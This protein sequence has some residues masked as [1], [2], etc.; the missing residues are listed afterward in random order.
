MALAEAQ[1]PAGVTAAVQAFVKSRGSTE[2]PK[3]KHAL[4]DLNGDSHKEA[5]VFLSDSN[6]CGSGGCTMLV[7]QGQAKGFKLVSSSTV[8]DTPVRVSSEKS[9]GWKHLLVYS[10]GKG[11]VL[12][13]FDGKQY[14]ANPS[15]QPKATPAQLKSAQILLK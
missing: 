4:T 9:H 3:F 5:V 6:W 8:T 2:L 10:K 7:L 12:M 11:D 14:P 15:L 1:A 13:R